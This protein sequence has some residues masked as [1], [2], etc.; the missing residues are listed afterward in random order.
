MKKIVTIIAITA[1]F[2]VGEWQQAYAGNSMEPKKAFL[3]SLAV[4]GLGQY[5][6]GANGYAKIF[7]AVEIAL[8]GNYYYNA[9]MK[10]STRD[11]YLSYAALHA[12]VNPAGRGTSYLNA[13]GSFNSSFDYNIYQLQRKDSPVSYSGSS[14]WQWGSDLERTRFKSLRE[15]ELNYENAV[16]YCVAGVV[17]NHLLSALHASKYSQRPGPPSLTIIPSRDGL[18]ALYSR[19]Y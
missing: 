5:Y 19:S 11:N 10:N 8:W 17:L 1:S 7:L 13:V 6:S 18:S 16:K 4:P 2:I 14:A 12:G 3:M 9:I 15:R